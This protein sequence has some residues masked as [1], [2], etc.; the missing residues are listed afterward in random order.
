M[1]GERERGEVCVCVWRKR[2]VRYMCV[3]REREGKYVCVWYAAPK[4]LRPGS[5]CGRKI[6]S[7]RPR[8]S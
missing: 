6:E 8:L 1:C 7:P 4:N 2:E 3:W 5:W